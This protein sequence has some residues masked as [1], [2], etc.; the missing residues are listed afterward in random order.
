MEV[1]EDR[2]T[3]IEGDL[4]DLKAGQTRL[5]A[6]L[7]E[8]DSDLRRHMLVLHEDLV[9]RIKTIADPSASL[10]R[11]IAAGDAAVREDLSRRIDP[12]ELTV[13]DHS[14]DLGR[15]RNRRRR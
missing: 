4:D 5:G 14:A 2:L 15:L 11:E 7:E 12:L 3:R 9:D 10:R 13:R 1:S 8:L 6:R